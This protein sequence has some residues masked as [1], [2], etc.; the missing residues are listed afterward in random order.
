[1]YLASVAGSASS[2][3]PCDRYASP[4]G[5]DGAPGTISEP[6]RTVDKLV[7][8][9]TSGETGCL[10]GYPDG[11]APDA[12]GLYEE[13]PIDI[14]VPGIT[15]RSADG[16]VAQ[17]KGALSITAGDVTVSHLVLDGRNAAGDASPQI[18]GSNVVLAHNNVTTRNTANC[19]RVTGGAQ[20]VSITH[21]RIHDCKAGARVVNARNALVTYN[22]VYDNAGTGV[23]LS[24]A[25]DGAY[26]VRNIIDRNERGIV[27][28]SGVL[29]GDTSVSTSDSSVAA[30]NIVS[31]STGLNVTADWHDPD[32][33]GPA[34]P[35][36]GAANGFWTNCVY[37]ATLPAGGIDPG[38]T[39]HTWN[40]AKIWS[41][42]NTVGDPQYA[43]AERGD[44]TLAPSS[45][46]PRIAGD[47]SLAVADDGP[48]AGDDRPSEAEAVNLRPNVLVILTDDQR[49]DGT[50]VDGVMP[51]TLD[52][53][54]RGTPSGAP[55]GTEFADAFATTPVCCPSRASIFTGQYVHNHGVNENTVAPPPS[56]EPDN[57]TYL[58]QPH[59][60]QRY[61]RDRAGYRTGLFGKFMNSWRFS[62]AVIV[63]NFDDFGYFQGEPQCP[64]KVMQD[65]G[66]Q[67]VF[68]SA[69]TGD[70]LR[71]QVQTPDDYSTTW[72]AQEGRRFIDE[73]EGSDA[74]PWLL[75]LTPV[76]PHDDNNTNTP[77][78]EEQYV[79]APV[80]S[81]NALLNS[82]GFQEGLKAPG[83][84]LTDKP[85]SV[86]NLQ[87]PCDP[88]QT[89]AEC[90]AAWTDQVLKKRAEQLRTLMSVDDLVQSVFTKLVQNGEDDD[91]LAFFV[92]DNGWLW[93]EHGLSTKGRPYLESVKVPFFLRWPD[94]PRVA[95][96][97]VDPSRFAANIDIAPTVLDAVDVTPDHVPD[98]RSLIDPAMTRSRILTEF[99]RSGTPNWASLTTPGYQYTEYYSFADAGFFEYY[100]F[101]GDLAQVTN[102]FADG[103]PGD[104][105]PAETD[106]IA[107]DLQSSRT[108]AGS[109]CP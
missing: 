68:G 45:P 60:V 5:D 1:V 76:A 72:V 38:T 52:W 54:R 19:I 17:V 66:V 6:F 11:S 78:P 12:S 96:D 94:N 43:D 62:G 14:D 89:P 37:H 95:R 30:G 100:R 92:S 85:P 36:P 15:L 9:V 80:P 28:G 22:A 35:V 77:V 49:A 57:P 99:W 40:P 26:V 25:A 90:D 34:A 39:S 21:N 13:D 70:P 105:P 20:Q 65:P 69:P 79:D 103:T 51:H 8:S 82:A 87:A 106:P 7:H 2:T 46:C 47:L 98:G 23:S 4:S 55:G 48:G 83:D 18:T 64:F 3:S 44:F 33:G 75:Y 56:V 91:T 109:S 58:I 29:P 97:T 86:R 81:A 74:Q 84:Q 10:L 108:C 73:A 93:G 88:P 63:P 16:Q 59:T 27:W 61:L 24:P 102:L 104:P 101:P 71:C 53:F 50:V 67:T 107:A 32:G 41:P 42:L 31:N